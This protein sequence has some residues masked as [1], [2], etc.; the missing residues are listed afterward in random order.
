[1]P[2]PRRVGLK[3]VTATVSPEGFVSITDRTKDVIKSGGGISS[4]EVENV[5]T[6]HPKV[7]EA[8][9]GRVHDKWGGDLLIVV[10]APEKSLHQMN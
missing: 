9:I 1:M 10:K 4:I 5:A 7:A 2:T 3:R 8:V 6:G